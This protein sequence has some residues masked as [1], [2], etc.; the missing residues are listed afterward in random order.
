ME[1]QR[2]RSPINLKSTP[3]IHN[4]GFQS[5]KGIDG[6]KMTE[7]TLLSLGS[8]TMLPCCH[9]PMTAK[10]E[11]APIDLLHVYASMVVARRKIRQDQLDDEWDQISMTIQYLWEKEKGEKFRESKMVKYQISFIFYFFIFQKKKGKIRFSTGQVDPPEAAKRTTI[12]KTWK[13]PTNNEAAGPKYPLRY[14]I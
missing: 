7:E 8:E 10:V 13:T 9:A 5:R 12:F 2:Y 1:T 11:A 14:R 3:V 6:R 4:S